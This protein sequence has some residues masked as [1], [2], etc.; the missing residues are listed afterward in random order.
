MASGPIPWQRDG[1]KRQ[2]WQTL[3]AWA[4]KSLQM[5][6]TAMKWKTSAPW[7]NSY[8]QPRQRIKKQT[9]YFADKVHLVKAVVF[10]VFM[11]EC[12]SWTIKKVEH[13]RTDALNHGVGRRL[14]RVPWTERRSNQPI[15][16]EINPEYSLKELM[17]RLKLQYFGHLTLRA[18]SLGKTL[19]LRKS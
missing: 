2:Q 16:N 10:P 3:F 18:D 1:K 17:L 13:W 12:Q 6:T 8:G 5:M 14:L 19:M 4:P 7:K 11:Y 9:H 15:L